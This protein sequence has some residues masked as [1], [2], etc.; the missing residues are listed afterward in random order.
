M[1]TQTCMYQDNNHRYIIREP[2][3]TK[4]I[5]EGCLKFTYPTM[6][7]K[8]VAHPCSINFPLVLSKNLQPLIVLKKNCLP[9]KS[10]LIFQKITSR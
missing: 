5:N 9:S 7:L 3:M 8:E 2:T 4:I 6:T 10:P 1:N